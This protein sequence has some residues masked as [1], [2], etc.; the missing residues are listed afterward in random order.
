[1][2]H[3]A[4]ARQRL[5]AKA[6]GAD[7]EE[8]FIAYELAGGVGGQGQGE[9]GGGNARTVVDDA[10]EGAAA[11]FDLDGD[12]GCA[13]VEGVFDQLLDDGSGALDDLTGGDA[14]DQVGG[15]LVDRGPGHVG[16]YRGNEE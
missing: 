2:G 5:A 10:E 15:E 3:G 12:V 4:D 1:M 7:A 11:V 14:I 16:D 6:H 13:G 8:V 9:L